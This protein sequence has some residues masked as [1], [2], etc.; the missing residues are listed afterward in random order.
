VASPPE[1]LPIQALSQ[2]L[3]TSADAEAVGGAI[4]PLQWPP[5]FRRKEMASG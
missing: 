5:D 2:T 1:G 3:I 4:P